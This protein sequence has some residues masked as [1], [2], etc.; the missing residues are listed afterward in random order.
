MVFQ[1]SQVAFQPSQVAFRPSQ[2]AIQPSQVPIPPSQVAFQSSQVAFQ[3]RQAAFQPSQVAIQPSQVAFRPSQVAFRPSQVAIQPSQVA[4]C[5]L[6]PQGTNLIA[7]DNVTGHK[8]RP[9]SLDPE[10]VEFIF[11]RKL[12]AVCDEQRLAAKVDFPRPRSGPSESS[13]AIYRWDG[14]RW[15]S[16]SAKRT[17]ENASNETVSFSRPLRGLGHIMG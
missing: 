16:Q 10:R 2:V 3:P 12:F 7:G 1:S 14:P 13:P 9:D 5:C 4:F 15:I 8:S 17:A 11:K 6:S